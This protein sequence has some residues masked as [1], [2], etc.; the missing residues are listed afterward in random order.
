MNPDQEPLAP[1]NHAEPFELAVLAVLLSKG[2]NPSK[3]LP[4]AATLWAQAYQYR[5]H[6]RNL[7][8]GEEK[9]K[10]LERVTPQVLS[11]GASDEMMD[12]KS[13]CAKY[14]WGEKHLRDLLKENLPPHVFQQLWNAP[15][16]NI[17][18][19]ITVLERVEKLQAEKRVARSRKG[20]KP[21]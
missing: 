8:W 13:A 3:S 2:K 16:R 4:A 17:R 20:V 18:L 11:T 21:V 6:L 10:P 14:S 5:E 7:F 1:F 19:P 9:S 15:I 12:V